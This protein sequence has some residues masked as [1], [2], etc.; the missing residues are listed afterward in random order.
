MDGAP[1]GVRKLKFGDQNDIDYAREVAD[2][3]GAVW[4][5]AAY[6]ETPLRECWQ[7]QYFQAKLTL[8]RGFTCS[9]YRDVTGLRT[10]FINADRACG[11]FVPK[12]GA[13]RDAD[14]IPEA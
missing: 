2:L 5:R 13:V 6:G 3:E 12:P 9:R 1:R 11:L 14:A 10:P 7:C 4:M 8:T